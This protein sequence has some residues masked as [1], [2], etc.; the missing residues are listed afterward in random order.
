MVHVVALKT[1]PIYPSRVSQVKSPDDPTLAAL[2]WDKTPIKVPTEYSDYADVFSFDL[3]IE[4]P[5]NIG[6]N[7]H[8]IELMKSASILFDKKPDGNFCLCID[9][10]GLNNLTIKNYYPLPLI[11]KTLD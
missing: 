7:K 6:I 9:Y 2:Q 11:G 5:K 8:G 3:A 1:M 10:Q 4:L